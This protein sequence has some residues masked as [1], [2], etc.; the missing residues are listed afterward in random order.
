MMSGR[1]L[2]VY[3]PNSEVTVPSSPGLL[4]YTSSP[5]RASDGVMDWR[6]WATN[7]PAEKSHCYL[8]TFP[9]NGLTSPYLLFELLLWCHYKY[10]ETS[11]LAS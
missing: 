4:W 5:P 3:L 2:P 8:L 1:V 11:E 10:M 9:L 6:Q 7:M